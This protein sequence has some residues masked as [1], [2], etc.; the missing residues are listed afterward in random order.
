[1]FVAETY[2]EAVV[3]DFKGNCERRSRTKIMYDANLVTN[4][5]EMLVS[6]S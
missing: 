4:T 6:G 5:Y 2:D 1:M 3:E